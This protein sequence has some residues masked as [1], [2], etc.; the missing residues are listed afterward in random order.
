MFGGK[1]RR[2]GAYPKAEHLKGSSLGSANIR[3]GWKG[4][5]NTLVYYKLKSIDGLKSLLTRGPSDDLINILPW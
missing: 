1:A 2:S 3:L 5:T 4:L